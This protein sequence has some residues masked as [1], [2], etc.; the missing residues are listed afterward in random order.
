MIVRS[1]NTCGVYET[2]EDTMGYD[3]YGFPAIKGMFSDAPF[4]SIIT[5]WYNM[6]SWLNLGD[7]LSMYPT[8]TPGHTQ[9]VASVVFQVTVATEMD[10][11]KLNSEKNADG[12]WEQSYANYVPGDELY[13]VYMGGYGING[14]DSLGAGYRRDAF[15]ASLRHLQSVISNLPTSTDNVADG[16]YNLPQHTNQFPFLE[17][18]QLREEYNADPNNTEDFDFLHFLREGKDEVINF[19]EK[20]ASS[21][22][23]SD[24]TAEY[25]ALRP[26]SQ[27]PEPVYTFDG[28]TYNIGITSMNIKNNTIEDVGPFKHDTG[29]TIIQIDKNIEILV[30]HGYDSFLNKGVVAADTYETTKGYDV[31][32]GFVI[33]KDC[34]VNDPDVWYVQVGA[35]VL[36]DYD[37]CVYGTADNGNFTSGPVEAVHDNWSEI[38]RTEGMTKAQA[39]ALAATLSNGSYYSVDLKGTGDINLAANVMDTFTEVENDVQYSTQTTIVDNVATVSLYVE[40]AP[41]LNVVTLNIGSAVGATYNS[42]TVTHSGMTT[43]GGSNLAFA[44]ANP[45]DATERTLIGTVTFDVT[46][47]VILTLSDIQ[48]AQYLGNETSLLDTFGSFQISYKLGTWVE[49]YDIDGD[50]SVNAGDLSLIVAR[51]MA[52]TG[53]DNFKAAYDFNCDGVLDIL[54]I[55][56]LLIHFN[57]ID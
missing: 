2:Y 49:L 53:D 9:G 37:G 56:N 57:G 48:I 4:R 40:N 35:H 32:K 19:C 45:I 51:F 26:T 24:Y 16:I 50:N 1:G 52:G 21:M 43:V 42:A 31:N 14:L 46:S 15:V 55:T 39:Q 5:N 36:D 25:M 38:I 41:R 33:A 54:D 29:E 27:D 11:A 8:L 23:Y 47:D 28:Q 7:G 6:D 3:I 44:W 22:L 20:R 34:F 13:F 12:I 17:T 10:N 18:Q 30:M